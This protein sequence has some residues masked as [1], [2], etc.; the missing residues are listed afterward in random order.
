MAILGTE[1]TSLLG[2]EGTPKQFPRES[3]HY[4]SSLTGQGLSADKVPSQLDLDGTTPEKYVD[5]LPK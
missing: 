4:I 2:N 1:N 3:I 5:N